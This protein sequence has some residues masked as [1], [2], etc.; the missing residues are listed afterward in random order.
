MDQKTSW[1]GK[2][3]ILN[4]QFKITGKDF[5]YIWPFQKMFKI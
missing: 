5:M 3:E 1:F 4:L 2:G